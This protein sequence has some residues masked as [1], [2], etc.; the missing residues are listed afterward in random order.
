[1]A[2]PAQLELVDKHVQDAVAKGA[3][4]TTGGKRGETGLFYAPT[5][6][7]DVDH[8]MQCM[9]DETFGPTLPV[10]KVSSEEEAIRLANDSPYG[11]SGSI[12][13]GDPATADRIARRL[14]TGSVSV[15]NA[16]ASIFQF[17]LPMGGWKQSGLGVRF[18]G[19]TGILKYCKQQS[20]CAERIELGSE[21]HWYPYTKRK[22]R[23][24]A[25]AVRLLGAH[26]WRR[27]L[28]RKGR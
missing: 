10:M 18:G 14:D 21:I 15:N 23:I 25:A 9:T 6:L 17:P 19:P 4:V 24:A 28:G 7:V 11:L 22:N 1:M 12:W 26:D 16:M 2:T 13:T 27:R 5:V 3:R 20:Y 8:T